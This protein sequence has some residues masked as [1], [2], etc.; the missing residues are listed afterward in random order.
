MEI[1]IKNNEDKDQKQVAWTIC[2]TVSHWAHR[3]Y[4]SLQSSL[5]KGIKQRQQGRPIKVKENAHIIV[6]L[7]TLRRGWLS[8]LV[9]HS[10]QNIMLAC[11][12]GFTFLVFM[13]ITV[14]GGG[15]GC[16]YMNAGGWP[17][18]RAV[19]YAISVFCMLASIFY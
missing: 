4:K 6:T 5:Q 8:V 15:W 13:M 12:Y 9:L 19:L 11:V 14:E 1:N 3:I 18:W 7:P 2:L 10:G 16:S 17:V